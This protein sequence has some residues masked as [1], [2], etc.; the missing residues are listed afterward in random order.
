MRVTLIS[1]SR[2][3][4]GLSNYS[5]FSDVSYSSASVFEPSVSVASSSM[6]S[7]LEL[8]LIVYHS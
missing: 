6:F 3:W 2:V 8:E 1:L 7:S 5:H 4:G